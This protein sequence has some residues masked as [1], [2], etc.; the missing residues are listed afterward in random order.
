[1]AAMA[2]MSNN[3]NLMASQ[4]GEYQGSAS[5]INGKG[6]SGMRFVAKAAS[7]SDFDAWVNTVKTSSSA[8]NMAAYEKLAK[9]SENNPK[10]FYSPVEK[11]L[12]NSIITKFMSPMKNT[13]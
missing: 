2:G 6:L 4:E 13:Q 5:E 1:M 8:L 3:L 7:Q 9:P 10:T 11:D 12:Q